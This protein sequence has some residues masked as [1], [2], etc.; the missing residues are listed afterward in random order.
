MSSFSEG[1]RQSLRVAGVD[2]PSGEIP[3]TTR[4]RSQTNDTMTQEHPTAAQPQDNEILPSP[5]ETPSLGRPYDEQTMPKSNPVLNDFLEVNSQFSSVDSISTSNTTGNQYHQ[6]QSQQ[7]PQY[8][9]QSPEFYPIPQND[10]NN[11]QDPSAPSP[12]SATSIFMPSDPPQQESYVH[13]PSTPSQ[14][15]INQT[16]DDNQP[17]PFRQYSH[18][19]NTTVPTIIPD[20]NI[21][22]TVAPWSTQVPLFP[23]ASSISHNK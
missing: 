9:Q 1:R 3:P 8:Y 5:T 13:H 23:E 10:I 21:V 14:S 19:P 2:P 12:S 15:N 6:T 22:E 17:L 20:S 4:R 18:P 16:N 7:V 11:T